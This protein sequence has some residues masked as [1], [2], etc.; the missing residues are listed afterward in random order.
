VESS[1]ANLKIN[2]EY[3]RELFTLWTSDEAMIPDFPSDQKEILVG[4]H[5]IMMAFEECIDYSEEEI[6]EGIKDRNLFATDHVQIRLA[7][8]NNG[9]L[10][11]IIQ[12]KSTSYR[13]AR[14][15]LQLADWDSGIP[16]VS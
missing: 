15:F 9:F 16:G 10:S 2:P 8:L 12:D 13:S 3:Y 1:L 14:R 6:D 5:F 11:Q 7:L 4:L